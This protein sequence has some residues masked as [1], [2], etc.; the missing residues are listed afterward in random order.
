[1][2]RRRS[3]R[4]T[5][6]LTILLTAYALRV[7]RL[8]DQ[9]IWWD[10]GLAIWAV[11]KSFV[12]TTL[13][14]AGDVHPPLYFW[15]LWP[16]VH[17][18]GDGEFAARYLTLSFGMLTVALGYAVGRRLGN[19]R[20]GLVAML[21]IALSRFEVWWSQEMRMYMFAG[22]WGLLSV[23][24]VL[25]ITGCLDQEEG[26]GWR[27]EIRDWR[28]EIGDWGLYVFA[29][30]A[31]LYTLYLAIVFVIAENL[32]VLSLA[33]WG[34]RLGK[35][36]F[37]RRWVLSQLA[38]ALLVLP[39]L[40]LALPRMQSW[41]V[42]EKPPTLGFVAQLFATLLAT[43]ISTNLN[44]VWL[45]T[46]V[47]VGAV[48][49]FGTQCV[50]R[51]WRLEIGDWR[52][53]LFLLL[54]LL[55]PFLVWLVTQPRSIFYSP[56]VEA[57]YLLPFA[58]PVYV[59]MA[60]AISGLQS[61]ISSLQSPLLRLEIRDWR[62]GAGDWRL[63][64][65]IVLAVFLWS[66]P[67]HYAGR[68]LRDDLQTMVRVIHAY[69]RPGDGVL[70]V[71][72]NRYPVFLYYYNREF[73]NAAVRPPV[74]QLPQH[75]LQLTPDNVERELA[76]LEARHT[77]LWLAWVNGPM[78]DPDGLAEKWLNARR[79]RVLSLGFA[80]NALHLY[81]RT[82]GEPTVPETGLAG[83]RPLQV[84]SEAVEILGYDLTTR[85]FRPG[86]TIRLGIY[87][88]TTQPGQSLRVRWVP[89]D[90]PPLAEQALELPATEAAVIR[91]RVE[92]RISEAV[93]AG[94]YRFEVRL[95]GEVSQTFGRLT[96][97]HTRAAPRDRAPE[98]PLTARI[99]EG[100]RF[101]GYSLR[102]ARGRRV[103]RVQRGQKLFIDLYWQADRRPPQRHTVFVHLLGETFNPATNGPVWA[104]HDSEPLLGA[105][106]TTQWPLGVVLADR[107]PVAIDPNVPSG[108]YQIEIGMYDP[109]TGERLPVSG[110][111]AD[112]ANRRLLVGSVEI[113]P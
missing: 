84:G 10:E 36:A 103:E 78:Q 95:P 50:V 18:V 110:D 3:L 104:G 46:A 25:R 71:S 31:A 70:L 54:T 87:A 93:P 107:H 29:T 106:P 64:L 44:E 101:L 41:R 55:P 32:W 39:W 59:L 94:A 37:L 97:T 100:Y 73:R 33:V 24:G 21:L 80:H 65:T 88:R 34:K 23:Y 81:A 53:P 5:A 42:V 109:T 13:W 77:R 74:Y 72:G 35:R 38:I 6:L 111:G 113:E 17:L 4:L 112:P 63:P 99:G 60:W 69:A 11:Q 85:E 108:T 90:G 57:R 45:P 8:G 51:S 22:F 68:Y 61:P 67:Q 96:V 27:S 79:P 20:T 91:R 43:G 76:P 58:A 98:H 56:R 19:P 75:A 105:L 62:L 30:A 7:Y 52:F 86:D 2:S 82:P 40:A 26:G 1:M 9:N 47:V 92:F 66:L 89:E 102:D 15:M 16:W 12:G 83:A 49:V 28:L 14:T 48:V